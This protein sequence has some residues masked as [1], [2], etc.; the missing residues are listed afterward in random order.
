[1]TLR[2]LQIM[3]EDRDIIVCCKP[4]GIPVQT[5]RAGQQDMES[6]L[7]NHRVRLGEPP[8]IYVVHRLDQPVAGVMVFAKNR[9]AAEAL[10]KQFREKTVDKVY[11]AWVEG[12]PKPREGRLTDYL[13]RDGKTNTS[14]VVSS[15]VKGARRAVLRYRVLEQQDGPAEGPREDSDRPGQ[16][17]VEIR[18]ETGRHH[19]I[20]VQLAHAGHPLVGDR[21][22]NPNCGEE[23]LPI[24]LCS[25][26]LAFVHPTDNLKRE[27]KYP[28]EP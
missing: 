5:A 20:R 4:A 1:M 8:E 3:E 14:R 24:R 19:Q 12:R 22:Y 21:K 16:S 27:Y 10:G 6:L 11:H 2:Q 17:L 13:L 18:L 9:R 7:K 28:N 15:D 23:Y 25:V 26:Q